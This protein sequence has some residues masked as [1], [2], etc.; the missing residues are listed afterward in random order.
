MQGRGF[1]TAGFEN[2]FHNA[3][4]GIPTMGQAGGPAELFGT[5]LTIMLTKPGQ[6]LIT[7]RF[8]SK[9]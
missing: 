5:L 3:I 1:A 8:G 9:K 6:S 7:G 4:R 2:G